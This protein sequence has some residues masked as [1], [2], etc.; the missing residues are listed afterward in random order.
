MCLSGAGWF[1]K[2][3]VLMAPYRSIWISNTTEPWKSLGVDNMTEMLSRM[4]GRL[5]RIK[6]WLE[7]EGKSNP[8]DDESFKDTLSLV[9]CLRSSLMK[10]G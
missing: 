8:S 10:R 5:R 2:D 4:E 3:E 1:V 9:E 7:H 6:V